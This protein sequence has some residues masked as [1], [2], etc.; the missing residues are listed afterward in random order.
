M[1]QINYYDFEGGMVGAGIYSRAAA[2]SLKDAPWLIDIDT[3][4]GRKMF[5]AP[6]RDE[7]LESTFPLYQNQYYVSLYRTLFDDFGEPVGVI[8]IKQYVDMMF[9]GFNR[10]DSAVYVYDGAGTQIV[11]STDTW[12]DNMAPTPKQ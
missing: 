3:S 8:E 7:L 4:S 11:S 12:A 9:R 2:I 10:K 6:H 1:P 5:T